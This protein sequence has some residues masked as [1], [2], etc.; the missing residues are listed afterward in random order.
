MPFTAAV[1]E[2]L[3][4]AICPVP[5]IREA[6]PPPVV[7]LKVPDAQRLFPDAAQ[8]SAALAGLA[9]QLADWE[10]SH[11]LAQHIDTPEGSFWHAIL[12]RMEPDEF[13]SNYW[14]RKVGQHGIFPELLADAK[15]ILATSPVD[16]WQ[17]A[18]RWQ[19]RLFHTWI[20]EAVETKDP[21]KHTVAVAIQ[22]A[23]LRRLFMYSAK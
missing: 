18:D 16:G 19:P 17:M 4:Q 8:P 12:H 7:S 22:N 6:F 23:E 14:F 2:L 13:N 10:G 9:L 3:A 20:R 5:L 11:E 15:S 21:R 1:E